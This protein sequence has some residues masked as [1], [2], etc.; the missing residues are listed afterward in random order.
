QEHRDGAGRGGG[1]HVSPAVPVHIDGGDG[2]RL[3]SGP[4]EVVAARV[5]ELAVAA[6]VQDGN[7]AAPVRV[8]VQ[9]EQGVRLAGPGDVADR[10]RSDVGVVVLEDAVQPLETALPGAEVHVGVGR[11]DRHAVDGDAFAAFGGVVWG[12]E[13]GL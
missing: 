5:L 3:V 8:V 10:S 12:H 2:D 11:I 4:E 7:A 6:A 9:R 1:H 13:V